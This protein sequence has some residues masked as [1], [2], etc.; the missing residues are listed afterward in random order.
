MT[1][2]DYDSDCAYDEPEFPEEL[3]PSRDP[4]YYFDQDMVVFLVESTLFKLPRR[5]LA[6]NSG[7]FAALFMSEPMPLG[8]NA[9][10]ACDDNPFQMDEEK[11]VD[12]GRFLDVFY[13]IHGKCP[14]HPH[15]IW[16]HSWGIEEWKSVLH[17][18]DKC[19]VSHVKKRA[20]S[21]L[22]RFIVPA[23]ER[24]VLGD[25]YDLPKASWRYAG[26]VEIFFRTSAPSLSDEEVN[27]LGLSLVLGFARA[28]HA[29]AIRQHYPTQLSM[30]AELLEFLAIPESHFPDAA[31][32]KVT[33]SLQMS[34]RSMSG[35][36][37]Y[38]YHD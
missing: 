26:L 32:N 5:M 29:N 18:G 9:K 33:A 17:L 25:R 37:Y 35:S 21:E 11:L 34:R 7:F 15:E 6:F 31:L 3:P 20:V 13:G 24:I 30:R 16:T 27:Y 38:Y 22:E 10:G 19:I 2:S 23:F 14:L 12:F 36:M 28:W 4:K 8:K 1:A